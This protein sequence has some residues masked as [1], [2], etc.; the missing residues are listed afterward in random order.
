MAM[1]IPFRAPPHST[2]QGKQMVNDAA[3][4]ASAA[5]LPVVDAAQPPFA[6]M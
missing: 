5:R 1:R 4:A 3:A 6:A 2:G